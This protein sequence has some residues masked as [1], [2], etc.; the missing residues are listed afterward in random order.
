MERVRRE[1]WGKAGE[2]RS[3]KSGVN[4][5]TTQG[6]L[7]CRCKNEA[8]SQLCVL[9]ATPRILH[10]ISNGPG[11]SGGREPA[12]LHSALLACPRHTTA[13]PVRIPQDMKN[14][15]PAAAPGRESTRYWTSGWNSRWGARPRQA[16]PPLSH[17]S[18][19]IRINPKSHCRQRL[20]RSPAL[21]Q[22]WTDSPT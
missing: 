11:G 18:K 5:A 21:N 14:N 15:H 7:L 12:W 19:N 4:K 1:I 8:S 9:S 20:R 10:H 22:G 6:A 17:P 3:G 16:L 13:K 2:H